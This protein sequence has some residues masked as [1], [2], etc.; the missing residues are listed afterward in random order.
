MFNLTVAEVHTFYVLGGDTPVLVHNDG[1]CKVALGNTEGDT[2]AWAERNGFKHFMDLSKYEWKAPV[3]QMI[4]DSDDE[5][6]FNLKAMNGVGPAGKVD[7]ALK[8]FRMSDPYPYAT[9]EELA[10]IGRAVYH[11]LRSWD[12]IKFYDETG[13]RVAVAE[14]DWVTVLGKDFLNDSNWLKAKGLTAR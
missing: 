2:K 13:L 12:S 11:G 10:W 9:S 14:P 1:P 5:I 7:W 6:Q 3:K 8:D 4:E